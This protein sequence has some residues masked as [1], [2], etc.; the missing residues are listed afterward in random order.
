M[1]KTI[2]FILTI[3]LVVL[4]TLLFVSINMKKVVINSLSKKYVSKEITSKLLQDIKDT[5]NIENSET[6]E[7]IEN[8]FLN[9]KNMIKITEKYFDGI[10]NYV[11]NDKINAIN[12]NEYLNNIVNEN[13]EAL[14]KL[15][16]NVYEYDINSLNIDK[17]YNLVLKKVKKELSPKEVKIINYYNIFVSNSFSMLLILGIT[18]IILIIGI[19][20]KS[21]YKY[22]YNIAVAGIIS[23]F[24]LTFLSQVIVNNIKDL[25]NEV[26]LSDININN[27]I[28]SGYICFA[29][30]FIL[31]IIYLII[32]KLAN[33]ES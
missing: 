1:K 5:Y 31:I 25:Y 10:I 16:V 4:I 7:N 32:S 28:N 18:L 8:S 20:K 11:V 26:N 33:K 14:E 12:I 3:L 29:I 30:S 19:I 22:I 2:N 27:I 17:T 23:G 6:L 24:I 15:D 21:F 13:K 9:N